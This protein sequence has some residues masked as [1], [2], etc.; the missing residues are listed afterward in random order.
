MTGLM[1]I[2]DVAGKYKITKR[3]LRYYEEIGLLKS[4]RIGASQSRFYD[5]DAINNL[6]QILLLRSVNFSIAEISKVMLSNN[7]DTA[8]KIFINR[9]DEL[10]SKLSEL[11]YCKTVI[12]SFISI[13]KALGI[14]NVNVYQ[15]LKEQIYI[16]NNDERMINMENLYEGDIIRLE[17]GLGIIPLITPQENTKFFDDI[18]AM[19]NRLEAEANK[20]IPLIR[21]LDNDN[22]D[23]LQYRIIV[24][25]KA[26]VDNSLEIVPPIDRISEM[27][28]YLELIMKQFLSDSILSK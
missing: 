18:K 9:L 8:F 25:G 5:A 15:L 13:G 17:I 26:L 21:V 24:K 14:E 28:R 19:R 11:N 6:E 23:T 20:N 3:S 22:L 16:H 27:L 7:S 1:K 4:I 12:S 2:N 10:T